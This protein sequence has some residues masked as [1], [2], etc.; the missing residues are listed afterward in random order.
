MGRIRHWKER[1]DPK[2]D[3]VFSKR[4]LLNM[5][6][7]GTVDFG[8]PITDEM[9]QELGA[10]RLLIWWNAGVIQMAPEQAPQPSATFNQ[11]NQEAIEP[12]G[13]PMPNVEKLGGGWYEVTPAGATES[14]R[15]RG[16][17]ALEAFLN[18]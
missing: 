13:G 16:K 9:K 10:H 4:M 6:G 14:T 11:I 3:L 1:F 17:K 15:I 7:A 5:C 18:G 12:D 2:G 8:D